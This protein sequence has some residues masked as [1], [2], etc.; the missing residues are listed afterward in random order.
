MEVSSTRLT[1]FDNPELIG[2]ITRVEIKPLSEHIAP[3]Y[4]EKF[5]N[6]DRPNIIVHYDLDGQERNF[7]MMVPSM[8]G[9]S[10]SNL[11]RFREKNV[12]LSDDT[13]T[14]KDSEIVLRVDKN[15][16][17]TVAL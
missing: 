6:L 2:R 5:G 11:K 12:G 8:Q 3:E 14:W 1:D 15:G 4:H 10:R 17:P 16:Y 7:F 9:Y 13:D